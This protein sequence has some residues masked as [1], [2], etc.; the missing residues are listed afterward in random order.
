MSDQD[1]FQVVSTRLSEGVDLTVEYL[2]EGGNQGWS[3]IFES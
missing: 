2:A 3:D 1:E